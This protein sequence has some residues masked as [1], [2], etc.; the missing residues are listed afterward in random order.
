MGTDD[1]F[2]QHMAVA[3]TS[4]CSDDGASAGAGAGAGASAGSGS[5]D[6]SEDPA[7]PPGFYQEYV[8]E[9]QA[10]IDQNAQLEFEC[11]WREHERSGIPRCELTDMLSVKITELSARIE[12]NDSLW[13]NTAL[14]SKVL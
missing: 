3:S 10:I 9:V 6:S 2:G 7:S 12:D 4:S 5:M 8:K 13:A 14:R 11:I 1:E